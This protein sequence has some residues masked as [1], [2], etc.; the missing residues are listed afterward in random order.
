M[1]IEQAHATISVVHRYHPDYGLT[2]RIT[3]AVVYA[4]ARLLEGVDTVLKR[5]L[6]QQNL[7]ERKNPGKMTGY[8]MLVCEVFDEFCSS[9]QR[10]PTYEEAIELIKLAAKHYKSFEV[11][12]RRL[13]QE[14]AQIIAAEKREKIEAA[15]AEATSAIILHER[16]ALELKH[17]FGLTRSVADSKFTGEQ[18]DRL[19]ELVDSDAYKAMDLRMYLDRVTTVPKAYSTVLLNR[20]SVRPIPSLEFRP[21]PAHIKLWDD[22]VTLNR[23]Q[24][25]RNILLVGEVGE[26]RA[27]LFN[28]ATGQPRL[29]LWNV[30]R[31]CT[32][33]VQTGSRPETKISNGQEAHLFKFSI[34]PGVFAVEDEVTP[35]RDMRL[36]VLVDVGYGSN[37]EVYADLPPV[38]WDDFVGNLDVPAKESSESSGPKKRRIT[39]DEKRETPMAS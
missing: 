37:G 34:V 22:V 3:R 6:R 28:Y 10:N 5:L 15:K 33:I 14:R 25:P 31:P 38:R 20:F 35:E 2:T 30:L 24:M 1:V 18:L 16:R 9:T 21:R 13:L 36:T 27:Y 29:S 4:M 26:R 12:E 11:R 17:A 32:Q 8:N 23:N 39:E 7:C 19:Q